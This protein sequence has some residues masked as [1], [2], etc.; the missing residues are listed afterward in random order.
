VRERL[1]KEDDFQRDRSKG[2]ENIDQIEEADFAKRPRVLMAGFAQVDTEANDVGEETRY[3]AK[4]MRRFSR[5]L[6]RWQELMP[7]A[8]TVRRRQLQ[9][10]VRTY[11]RSEPARDLRFEEDGIEIVDDGPN[12]RRNQRRSTGRSR[13]AKSGEHRAREMVMQP[14]PSGVLAEQDD[15]GGGELDEEDRELLGEVDADESGDDDDED[16][17][18]RD[19]ED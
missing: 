5:R 17:D 19:D 3:M 2:K 16:M 14:S 8:A 9:Y 1:E 10:Q 4:S 18:P 13:T 7:G 6:D 11:R 15:D 12:A